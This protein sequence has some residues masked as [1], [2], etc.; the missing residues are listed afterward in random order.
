MKKK[1]FTIEDFLGDK[2]F[3]EWVKNPSKEHDFFWMKWM[4]NHP[5]HR[6]TLLK[7]RHI[8]SNIKYRELHHS[9][10][11]FNRVFDKIL[12]DTRSARYPYQELYKKDDRMVWFRVAAAI[13]FLA[14]FSFFLLSG[15]HEKPE[16]EET[17]QITFFEFNNPR[18]KRSSFRLPDSTYV[19]LNAESS[20]IIPSDFLENRKVELFGEAYFEVEKRF[21]SN[22]TVVSGELNTLVLG[23][24]F[25]IQSYPEDSL[26][27]IALVE[28]LVD[29]K[30]GS[31]TSKSKISL[32]PNQKLR[33]KRKTREYRKS[34]F[35][36]SDEIAW[37]D[38][39][40]VFNHSGLDEVKSKIERWY[41]VQV[42]IIGRPEEN[43]QLT[44]CFDNQNIINLAESIS[45]AKGIKCQLK[46]NE[47]ILK[48]N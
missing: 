3:V 10:E 46:D 7:A 34:D 1:K 6:P 45:F 31:D 35:K 40:L 16:S 24:K 22:F 23:T 18:G 43:W 30:N 25:N 26:I 9:E 15:Y 20:L 19:V 33:Y 42:K 14:I 12:M 36:A 2:N 32:E 29:V 28:G 13:S 4:E 39:M 17:S 37:K 41:D 48:F 5:E 21:G 8:L 27:S 38:G 11:R 44:G 47:L